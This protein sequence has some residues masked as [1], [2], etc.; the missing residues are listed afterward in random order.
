VPNEYELVVDFNRD[1]LGVP[2]KSPEELDRN[3]FNL[4]M[5]QLNEELE[6]FRDAYEG[7]DFIAQVDGL[8]DL[9]YFAYGGLYKMGVSPEQFR[10]V[11]AAVDSANKLKKKGVKKERGNHGAADA[12]K[13]E[14]WQDPTVL[15][16]RILNEG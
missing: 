15:I 6:E 12:F 5:T 10:R 4:L 16:G 3:V 2:Q 1:I 14:G 13:P 7:R 11:F 8:I 9:V